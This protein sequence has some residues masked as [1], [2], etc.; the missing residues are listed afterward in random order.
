PHW[1]ASA[2][3]DTGLREDG[4]GWPSSPQY[5]SRTLCYSL[6]SETGSRS[7]RAPAPPDGQ[8]SPSPPVECSAADPNRN[9]RPPGSLPLPL[10]RQEDPRRS[11]LPPDEP[12]RSKAPSAPPG[13]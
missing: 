8:S 5:N 6:P 9:H 3:A 10:R 7:L 12:H 13:T 2:S 1:P 4:E 11:P